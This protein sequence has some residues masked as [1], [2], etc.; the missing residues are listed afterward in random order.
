[1]AVT[2]VATGGLREYTGGLQELEVAAG[3]TVKEMLGTLG[4]RPELVAAVM[5]NRELV[6]KDYRPEDGETVVL[7]A[8]L[9]GG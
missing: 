3:P 8:V 7:V 4:I 5:R 1:M 2:L 6:S 9:G